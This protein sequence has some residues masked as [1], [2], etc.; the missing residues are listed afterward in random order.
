V[1]EVTDREL[2]LIERTAT[3]RRIVAHGS[4]YD[5]ALTALTHCSDDDLYRLKLDRITR[6][7]L[8]RRRAEEA[9]TEGVDQCPANVARG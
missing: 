9:T 1:P 2:I 6:L 8:A 5:V 3:G 4:A 7:Q